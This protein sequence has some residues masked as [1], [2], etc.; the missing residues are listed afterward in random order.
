MPHGRI[1]ANVHSPTMGM[2]IDMGS[3]FLNRPVDRFL[4]IGTV[5][6][7]RVLVEETWLAWM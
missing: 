3:P 7:S 4:K 5:G 1:F 2:V 6:A